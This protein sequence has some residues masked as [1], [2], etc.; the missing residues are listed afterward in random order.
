V[1]V[2]FLVPELPLEF[3]QSLKIVGGTASLG[4]W[5]AST[6][7]TLEWTEGNNWKGA[8][9]VEAGS[10]VEF[11]LVK[12]AGGDWSSWE[13]GENKVL[14]V[15]ATASALSVVCNWGGDL[16]IKVSESTPAAAAEKPKK[17]TK[18]KAAPKKV[19]EEKK[20]VKA[21]AAEPVAAEPVAVAAEPIAVA[22]EPIA[23]EPAVA[24][25]PAFIAVAEKEEEK[26]E[27]APVE[28]P[29]HSDNGPIGSNGVNL[30]AEFSSLATKI[31]VGSDGTL[32]IEFGSS[33]DGVTAASL[34]AKYIK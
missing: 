10:D 20:E 22:P 12:V 23:A 1:N 5:E 30:P 32:I 7:C 33:A 16:S 25:A 34:A 24:A 3:G 29:T 9:E 21:V 28:A 11:K 18:P 31:S 17:S 6:G 8:A 13:D 19:K 15:P 27:E 14:A 26:A 4:N 2:D